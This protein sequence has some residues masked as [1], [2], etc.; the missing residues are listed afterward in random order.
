M[1]KFVL[2]DYCVAEIKSSVVCE[3]CSCHR[4]K[5]FLLGCTPK[6]SIL[7]DFSD[8]FENEDKIDLE[9]SKTQYCFHCFSKKEDYKKY[10]ELINEN[11]MKELIIAFCEYNFEFDCYAKYFYEKIKLCNKLDNREEIIK[12]FEEICYEGA[13]SNHIR[14]VTFTI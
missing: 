13:D 10:L 12:L 9:N 6:P 2:S 5:S 14:P 4:K 3:N 8:G 7:F 1:K 11:I